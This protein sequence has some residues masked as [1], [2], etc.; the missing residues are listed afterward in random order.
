MLMQQF[1][2]LRQKS[3]N[4][5]VR[6]RQFLNKNKTS[7]PY[8]SGD[9]FAKYCDFS[10][11]SNT[12]FA[13]EQLIT[14]KSIFCPSEKLEEFLESYGDH[15]SAEVLIFGNTDRDFYEL[16]CNF[17]PSVRCVYLQNSHISDGFIRTLPI[18]IENLRYGRN[19]LP[20]LFKKKFAERDKN[21]KI[22]VGPFSPTHPERIELNAWKNIQHP[23]LQIISEHLQPRTLA[24][25]AS[26]YQFIAC[27][28][29]NGTDTHRFWET[30]YR[31]SIPVVK[32]SAWS[33]SI[34]EFDVPMIQLES[35]DFD[36]FL[37]QSE[38]LKS[39][40]IDPEGISVLWMQHW[41][42]VLN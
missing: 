17:P 28:R 12:E 27:P 24:S 22:L 21:G 41:E 3:F 10:I 20:P 8:I 15:I 25:L 40:R 31:G 30:L 19:G 29:G 42:R 38:A 35:W 36:E 6:G 9:A 5:T 23:R 32:K 33:E 11:Y 26:T 4:L 7:Y 18:G 13:Y 2:Y 34:K 14:A 37:M 16:N 39:H 1:K